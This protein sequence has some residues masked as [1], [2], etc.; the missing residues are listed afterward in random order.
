MWASGPLAGMQYIGVICTTRTCRVF[1]TNHQYFDLIPKLD[2]TMSDS[3]GSTIP[4]TPESLSE[5]VLQSPLD[6]FFALLRPT[7]DA[8]CSA[9]DAAVNRTVKTSAE[10]A[11]IRQF[12]HCDDRRKRSLSEFTENETDD[13]GSECGSDPARWTGAYKLSLNMSF[14]SEGWRLGTGHP[15]GGGP[16]DL[17]LAPPKNYESPAGTHTSFYSDPH[18]VSS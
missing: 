10:S 18:T 8:A 16:V 7:N 2:T 11:H 6:E 17:L 4:A 15:C 13:Q 1:R 12:L 3:D 14:P 5:D 9:F